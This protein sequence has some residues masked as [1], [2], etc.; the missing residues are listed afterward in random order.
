MSSTGQD[1]RWLT[2]APGALVRPLA[3]G[4]LGAVAASADAPRSLNDVE[5]CILAVCTRPASHREVVDLVPEMVDCGKHEVAT[6]IDG[7]IA[8]GLLEASESPLDG[9]PSGADAT[10]V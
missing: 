10:G 2:L 5:E 6:T 1:A 7:L 8:F 4:S 3:Q 9:L